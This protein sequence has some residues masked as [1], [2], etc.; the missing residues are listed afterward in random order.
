MESPASYE[1]PKFFPLEQRAGGGANMGGLVRAL[2]ALAGALAS[3]H[4][5][6]DV[7]PQASAAAEGTDL[8]GWGASP[9]GPTPLAPPAPLAAASEGNP[10]PEP[11]GGAA[12]GAES[13]GDSADANPPSGSTA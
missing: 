6:P 10:T 11:E 8:W 7:A 12:V 4:L 13:T 3:V 1:M 5:T 2:L 9:P